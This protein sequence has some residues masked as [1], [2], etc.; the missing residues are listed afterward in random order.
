MENNNGFTLVELIV[1]IALLGTISVVVGLSVTNMI[2]TQKEKQVTNYIETLENAACVYADKVG[3][4]SSSSLSVRRVKA[5][6]LVAS[7]L[8]SKNLTHPKTKK[9]VTDDTTIILISWSGNEKICKY[10]GT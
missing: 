5:A 10:Q 3:I 9:A 6:D 1:T 4:T 2:N 7:G 8:I